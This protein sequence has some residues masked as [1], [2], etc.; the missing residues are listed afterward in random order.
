MLQ[1][2]WQDQQTKFKKWQANFKFVAQLEVGD[3]VDV[4]SLD[5]VWTVGTVVLTIEQINKEPLLVIHKEGFSHEWDE[6]LYRNSPR[7][8]VKGSYTLRSDIQK[9][10]F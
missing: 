4:R 2:L 7:V 5:Y 6:L 3:K 8:A 9:F 10:T 1:A